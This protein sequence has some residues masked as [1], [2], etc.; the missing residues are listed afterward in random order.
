M[1]D[2]TH[3]AKNCTKSK[4]SKGRLF[5]KA[6]AC[7]E[8]SMFLRISNEAQVIVPPLLGSQKNIIEIMIK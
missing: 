1:I 5:R 7:R 4:N 8:V 6:T 3:F 2:C